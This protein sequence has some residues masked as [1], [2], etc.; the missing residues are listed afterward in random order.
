[1]D[2]NIVYFFGAG[3][4]K[5]CGYPT[6][7]E[8][9]NSFLDTL[10][11]ETTTVPTVAQSYVNLYLQIID[12]YPST[13]ILSGNKIIDIEEMY[14]VLSMAIK[15]NLEYFKGRNN[16][17]IDQT[18]L[19][20]FYDFPERTQDYF[21]KIKELIEEHINDTFWSGETRNH[22]ILSHLFPEEFM[23]KHRKH[24]SLFTT[25]Y[26]LSVESYFESI[27]LDSL[28]NPGIDSQK[29]VYNHD[30][31][32][33]RRSF[34]PYVKIHG[35]VNLF[36]DSNGKIR[37][38]SLPV[39]AFHKK[40]PNGVVPERYYINY[41]FVGEPDKEYDDS[42]LKLLLF[43]GRKI[44][45]ADFI[46]IIGSSMRDEIITHCLKEYIHDKEIFIIGNREKIM[47]ELPDLE[48]DNVVHFLS[49]KYPKGNTTTGLKNLYTRIGEDTIIK[50]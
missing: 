26:D 34:I 16:S 30:S 5:A 49:G 32:I 31:I 46:F 36:V 40:M 41:P 45:A 6:T 17:P 20:M 21:L 28:I 8:L 35:S 44:Q 9:N 50:I 39:R 1:M 4:S 25:N 2:S 18:Y 12:K 22:S 48:D 3:L 37:Y 38:T 29:K 15:R 11:K 13:R 33:R 27:G 7:L 10:K 42:Q 14:T 24:I 43:F 47:N 19:E 23:L